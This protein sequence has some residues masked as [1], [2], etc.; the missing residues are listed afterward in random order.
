MRSGFISYFN[1]F[2]Y[3]QLPALLTDEVWHD[4]LYKT[5]T[6]NPWAGADIDF[7]GQKVARDVQ[8]EKLSK[9]GEHGYDTWAWKQYILALEQENFCD[10]EV[11]GGYSVIWMQV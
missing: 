3:S 7:E 6:P 9:E 11:C 4:P 10:F 5:D 8:L 2:L 1:P